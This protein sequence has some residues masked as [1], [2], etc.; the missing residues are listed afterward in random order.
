LKSGN[1]HGLNEEESGFSG[2]HVLTNSDKI[3]R[4]VLGTSNRHERKRKMPFLSEQKTGNLRRKAIFLA[5]IFVFVTGCASHLTYD[6]T[7]TSDIPFLKRRPPSLEKAI[8]IDPKGPSLDP[9]YYEVMGKASSDVSHVSALAPH[10]DD[11]TEMLRLEAENVGGDALIDFSC[12]SGTFNARAEG[13]VIVFKNREEA[14][15]VLKEIKAVL[16]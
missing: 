5:G 11:A 1:G 4:F 8:I 3:Y 14:L 2:N 6:K 13:T 15:R 7:S 10:C 16:K 9:K 12:T